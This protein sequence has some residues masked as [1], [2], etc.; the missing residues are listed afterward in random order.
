MNQSTIG[1][2]AAARPSAVRVFEKYKIDF[3]CGGGRPLEEVCRERG[4]S[5]ATVLA[6]IDQSAREQGTDR[7]WSAATL[8]ALIG[9]IVEHHHAYVK[10]ELPVLKARMAKV[11]DAHG[12]KHPESLPALARALDALAAELEGHLRKEELILFPAI[13]ELEAA[14]TEG[15]RPLPPPFGTVRNPVRM[16]TLEHDSAGSALGQMR[17]LTRD[18]TL[19]EGACNT[20]RALYQGLAEFEAD[21][22]QHIHLENNILF[23]R[24]VAVEERLG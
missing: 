22:H 8:S 6:D 18:Y 11:I 7:D 1:E 2:I 12:A 21:L 15:R 4:L 10:S 3:C 17:R 5:A 23:P 9:H 16:M 19:P 20:F 13:Q 14:Q 24:A